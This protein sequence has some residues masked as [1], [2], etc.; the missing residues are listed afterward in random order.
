[1][2]RRLLTSTNYLLLGT[3]AE[4]DGRNLPYI[5]GYG[6]R[7]APTQERLRGISLD[8]SQGLYLRGCGD[9]LLPA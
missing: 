6:R 1:M 7:F 4:Y 5:G 2:C 8:A 9:L 3:W